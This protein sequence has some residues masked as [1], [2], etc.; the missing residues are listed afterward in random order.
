MGRTVVGGNA[1]RTVRIGCSFCFFLLI[2]SLGAK[3]ERVDRL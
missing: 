2:V 1:G 3:I